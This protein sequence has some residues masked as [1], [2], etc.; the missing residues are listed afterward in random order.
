M[1]YPD[2]SGGSSEYYQPDP[3]VSFPPTGGGGGGDSHPWK[4]SI[5]NDPVFPETGA[6]QWILSTTGFLMHDPARLGLVTKDGITTN[7]TKKGFYVNIDEV[8]GSEGTPI[9]GESIVYFKYGL[10]D[11]SVT[12]EIE[13]RAAQETEVWKRYLPEDAFDDLNN[14]KDLTHSKTPIALIQNNPDPPEDPT[15]ADKFIV[16][17][18][19]R[20]NMVINDSCFNG[21][22]LKVFI[23]M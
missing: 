1:P 2:Y 14:I 20:N 6:P 23:P 12:F 19:A 5:I 15:P 16:K 17:Q 8:T 3:L 7:G 13:T 21:Q 22:L 11:S 10:E 4:V 9:N 18:L